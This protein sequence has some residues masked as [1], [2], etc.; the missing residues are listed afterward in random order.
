[1]NQTTFAQI[2]YALSRSLQVRLVGHS[3][4]DSESD[5]LVVPPQRVCPQAQGI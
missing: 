4:H 5:V 3:G 1:M 2:M